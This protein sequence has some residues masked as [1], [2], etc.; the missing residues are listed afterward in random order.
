MQD[1]KQKAQAKASAANRVKTEKLPKSSPV[2][3]KPIA[4]D[5]LIS[6]STATLQGSTTKEP[7]RRILPALLPD[8]ILNAEPIHRLPSPPPEERQNHNRQHK[9]F[10]DDKPTKDIHRGNVTIKVLESNKD[11]LPPKTLANGRNVK[12]LWQAGKRGRHG[13]VPG[14]L[15]RVAAGSKGFVRR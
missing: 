1:E 4:D 8:E 9:F 11:M 10:K 6:E 3:L 2:E 15:K 14:G 12:A 5:D 7:S 13:G